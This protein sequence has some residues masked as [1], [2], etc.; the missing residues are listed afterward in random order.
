MLEPTCLLLS[1]MVRGE[2]GLTP[3]ARARGR[4]FHQQLVG[5]A[6]CVLYKFPGKGPQHAPDGNMGSTG[7][8]C[9]FLGYSRQSNTFI[10]HTVNGIIHA[11]SITRRPEGD[12]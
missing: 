2:D 7:C 9:V 1:V 12:R 11:R 6:E 4:A 5:V 10:V 3:W 8:E